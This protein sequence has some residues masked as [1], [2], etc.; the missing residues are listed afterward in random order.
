[1]A[2]K[3]PVSDPDER[4]PRVTE[5]MTAAAGVG[6]VTHGLAAGLAEMGVRRTTL[7]LLKVNQTDGF[8]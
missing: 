4:H 8:D 6:G 1:M 5:P 3:P 7:A 2:K